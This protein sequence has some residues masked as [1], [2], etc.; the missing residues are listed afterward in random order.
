MV[1]LPYFGKKKDQPEEKITFR[2][3]SWFHP[4]HIIERSVKQ[5]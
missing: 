4:C 3:T 1:N 2:R 5:K